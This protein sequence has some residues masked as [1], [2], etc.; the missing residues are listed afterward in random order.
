MYTVIRNIHLFLGLLCFSFLLMYSVSAVQMSHVEWFSNNPTVS[1]QTVAVSPAD[2]QNPRSF[3]HA[4]MQ[5][6]MWGEL[7]NVA[8]DDAGFRF[9]ILRAGTTHDVEYAAG[10]PT[11]QVK[12]SVAGFMG[13]LNRL[14]HTAGFYR[15]RC[16]T[17]WWAAL[18]ALTSLALL[19]LGATGVYMWFRLYKERV[20]GGIFLSI[21]LF[22]GLG[23]LFATRIQP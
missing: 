22:V 5:A 15:E 8:Q 9:R 7:Q 11:A 20:L 2:S 23:L 6:G 3:A 18:V 10:S 4:L 19:T 1:E 21:G 13:M 12:T 17:D 16:I 14:H